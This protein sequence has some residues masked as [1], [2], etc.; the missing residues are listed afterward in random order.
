MEKALAWALARPLLGNLPYRPKFV[1]S[2]GYSGAL[3]SALRVGDLVLA[4]E[5]ADMD[6]NCWPA[7]WPGALPIGEW[8]APLTRG[9]VLTTPDLVTDPARKRELGERHQALAVDMESAV[10]AR[11]CHQSG[12]PYGCLRAISD[13]WDTPL[14]PTLASLTP[15]GRVSWIRLL[16][17]LIR[18]PKLAAELGRLAGQTK[19]AARELG[20]GL[21]ELLTLTLNQTE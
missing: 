21:G 13:D 20:R 6:G 19:S 9:R 5:V 3:T 15:G 10:A 14:S 8:R 1:L 11:V 2:A 16:A 17:A 12:I 4:T 7:T 18:S